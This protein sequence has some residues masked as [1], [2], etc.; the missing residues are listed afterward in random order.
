MVGRFRG[1]DDPT[2]V[3]GLQI[4]LDLLSGHRDHIELVFKRINCKQV[5]VN[6]SPTLDESVIG[7]WSRDRDLRRSAAKA[8][9]VDK[10]HIITHSL[11]RVTGTHINLQLTDLL[12][13]EDL[14]GLIVLVKVPFHLSV[15]PV[16]IN[17]NEFRG[18]GLGND[19][20]VL[21]GDIHRSVSHKAAMASGIYESDAVAA[22]HERP[23]VVRA[24][25]EIHSTQTLVQIHS[26]SFQ[27]RAVSGSCSRMHGHDHHIRLLLGPHLVHIL[28]SQRNKALERHSAPEFLRQP[29]LHVGVCETQYGDLQSALLVDL[30]Q[31]KIRFPVVSADS[32]S[33]QKRNPVRLKVPG[34]A[35]IDLVTGLDVMVAHRD[36]I[37]AHVGGKAWIDM[38]RECV[39]IVEIVRGVVSLKAVPRIDED[40]FVRT[41]SRTDA[42]HYR[43]DG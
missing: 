3:G 39:H 30:V 1:S 11:V 23:V 9:R 32:V 37:V 21:N 41:G 40:N 2:V 10:V 35:V 26:L 24:D 27:H 8:K 22:G 4:V 15:N 25:H 14:H 29:V 28:L 19:L 42:V 33:S 16:G 17:R 38:R 5:L 6:Q 31:R 20:A 12:G 13:G 36:G 43:L 34:D 7:Q 18:M